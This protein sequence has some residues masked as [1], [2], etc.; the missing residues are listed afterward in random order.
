[1]TIEQILQEL[2]EKGDITVEYQT[3]SNLSQ[4]KRQIEIHDMESV[5]LILGGHKPKTYL[6]FDLKDFYYWCDQNNI[7][8]INDNK[9]R[10]IRLTL[11]S[12][13]KLDSEDIRHNLFVQIK[14]FIRQTGFEPNE[15]IM[16]FEDFYN[17]AISNQFPLSEDA[18]FM[19]KKIYI[20]RNHQVKK[21]QFKFIVDPDG[22]IN[23]IID[24]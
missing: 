10:V 5:G 20:D 15:I 17:L 1:M 21:G 9:H 24:D 18:E 12:Q 16:N 4:F 13:I 8:C 19:G 2:K 7:F 6:Q 14:N 11:K 22:L 3:I 23:N